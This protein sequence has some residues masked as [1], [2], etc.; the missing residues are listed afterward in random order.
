MDCVKMDM[1]LRGLKLKDTQDE[2]K[3]QRLVCSRPSLQVRG[4]WATLLSL[5]DPLPKAGIGRSRTVQL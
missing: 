5:A 3:W 2:N 1:W 4:R